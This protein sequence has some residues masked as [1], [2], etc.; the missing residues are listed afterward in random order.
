MPLEE[1]SVDESDGVQKIPMSSDVTMILIDH[2]GSGMKFYDIFHE[3]QIN[4]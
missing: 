3:S 4:Y 2:Y 1:R